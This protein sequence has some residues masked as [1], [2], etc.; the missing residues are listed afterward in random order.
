L[1]KHGEV[2]NTYEREYLVKNETT[3]KTAKVIELSRLE[4]YIV[5]EVYCGR[6]EKWQVTDSRDIITDVL[7]PNCCTNW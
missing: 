1:K 4:T 7:C 5:K 2:R 6:C 3:D